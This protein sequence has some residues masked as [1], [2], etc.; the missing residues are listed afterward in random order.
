MPDSSRL[1]MAFFL[2]QRHPQGQQHATANNHWISSLWGTCG[3]KCKRNKLKT[4]TWTSL[5]QIHSIILNLS[6]FA[7]ISSEIL[8]TGVV[9]FIE[10]QLFLKH[11]PTN[12]FNRPAD[13]KWPFF[14]ASP[15]KARKGLCGLMESSGFCSI[16]KDWILKNWRFQKLLH[17]GFVF[18]WSFSCFTLHM[19][20]SSGDSQ[21]TLLP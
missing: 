8:R 11:T 13:Q 12:F 1:H 16:Q 2:E 19:P 20:I 17:S 5:C 21:A 10:Q 15:G 18:N 3:L 7:T 4:R 6:A 9:Q 14:L